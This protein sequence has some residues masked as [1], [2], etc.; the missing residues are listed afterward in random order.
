[1]MYYT[2]VL[3]PEQVEVVGRG[4]DELQLKVAGPVAVAIQKQ[5]VEQNRLAAEAEKQ[6]PDPEPDPQN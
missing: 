4:L 5:I 2:L 1:M 6:K 3:T